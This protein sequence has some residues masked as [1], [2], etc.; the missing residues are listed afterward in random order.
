VLTAL[1]LSA[2]YLCV[3][4]CAM[5][6]SAPSSWPRLLFL[7]SAC[8]PRRKIE[9]DTPNKWVNPLMG[10][11]SAR[12]TAQQLREMLYFDSEAEARDFATK[13][14]FAIVV[15]PSHKK[16]LKAKSFSDNFKW[17]GLPKTEE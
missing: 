17:R 14:G 3:R 10:W 5:L 8:R 6:V 2:L 4:S 11:T 13:E 9:F 15:L 16:K 1:Y 7:S 12:D